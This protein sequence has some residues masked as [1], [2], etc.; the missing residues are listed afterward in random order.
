LIAVFNLVSQIIVSARRNR[1]ILE[2]NLGKI[3]ETILADI[4]GDNSDNIED[5][6]DIP[7][8]ISSDLELIN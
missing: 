2:D 3:L 1:E 6:G 4:A 8:G 5:T 7:T